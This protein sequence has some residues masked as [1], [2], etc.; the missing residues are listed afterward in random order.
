MNK[1]DIS[2]ETIRGL[3][4]QGHFGKP[5]AP[6][7]PGTPVTEMPMVVDID[8]IRFYEN[9]PRRQRNAEYDGIKESIRTRGV[10]NPLVIT[11]RPE[12]PPNSY[13]LA[14]G[15]NTR[16]QILKELYVETKDP[17]FKTVIC[18]FRPWTS[19]SDILAAH[20][21]ENDHR[22]DLVFIDRA[23]TIFHRLKKALE[24]EIGGELSQRQLAEELSK[25]GYK[26]V[27]RASIG[28]MQYAAEVLF[29][30][31]PESLNA[32]LG[33]REIEALRK[34]DN[35]YYTYWVHKKGEDTKVQR[36]AFNNDFFAVL[37]AGDGPELNIPEIR[38]QLD[39]R[40]AMRLEV[41]AVHVARDIDALHHGVDLTYAPRTDS[42]PGPAR[43]YEE[44]AASV[45]AP[46][47]ATSAGPRPQALTVEHQSLSESEAEDWA[48]SEIDAPPP[49]R[50]PEKTPTEKKPA[51]AQLRQEAHRH[52]VALATSVDLAACVKPAI[53]GSGYVLELPPYPLEM[54]SHAYWV[55]WLLLACSE[56]LS[57]QKLINQVDKTN[58]IRRLIAARQES[59]LLAHLGTA[60]P[61]HK[62]G[63]QLFHNPA[64]GEGDFER[65]LQLIVTC[66]H[67]HL[68]LVKGR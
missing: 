3:L 25:R 13:V 6:L 56:M 45:S 64:L 30:V 27:S 57:N 52:A 7:P 35:S 24:Q 36:E 29:H 67:I 28:L 50:R 40:L 59:Q 38:N 20:L 14:A 2:Q 37:A 46:A 16:L 44:D 42:H 4:V 51:T 32:G 23:V 33:Y 62:L 15:G 31:I 1:K 65:S 53:I 12:D 55:F 66:R 11:C 60:P 22:G 10:D 49:T 9:N 19:E 63:S 34:M 48:D 43:V 41:P 8:H 61:L 18:K 21:I 5:S 26:K 54:N 39:Q 68:S 47:F 17:E 58:S